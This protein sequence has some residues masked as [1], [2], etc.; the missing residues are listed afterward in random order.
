MAD[1]KQSD[2]RQSTPKNKVNIDLNLGSLLGGGLGKLVDLAQQLNENGAEIKSR[3][4]DL[5]KG[6]SG[7]QTFSTK[8]GANGVFGF[9]IKTIG[10]EQKVET[11]GNI[12]QEEQGPTLSSSREPLIDIIEANDSLTLIAE[13]P[14]VNPDAIQVTPSG[15]QITLEA[16][17]F[18]GRR[19]EK[20]IDLADLLKT[21][22]QEDKITHNYQNGILEITI[23]K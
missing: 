17:G 16:D 7:E 9:H 11:F 2:S 14:G 1:S 3:L 10:G 19:F 13:M 15:Q 22:L 23:K 18:G 8:S 21:P 20:I 5:E 4:Q 6:L 12:R